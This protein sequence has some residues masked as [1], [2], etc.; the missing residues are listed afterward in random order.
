MAY[1]PTY[2]E[3]DRDAVKK[4]HESQ[5]LNCELSKALNSQFKV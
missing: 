3:Q 5:T 1:K 2:T 4:E